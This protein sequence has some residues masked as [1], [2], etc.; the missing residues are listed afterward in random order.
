MPAQ[1][2]VEVTRARPAA[3][4]KLA[5]LTKTELLELAAAAGIDHRSSRTKKQLV[6]ALNRAQA[7]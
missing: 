5:D 6:D 2:A 1:G 4:G 3:T 7:R